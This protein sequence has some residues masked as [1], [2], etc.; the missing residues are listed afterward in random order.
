MGFAEFLGG[1]GMCLIQVM[2]IY[3]SRKRQLFG[4][5]SSLLDPVAGGGPA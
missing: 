4:V 2:C 5:L 1:L 3:L